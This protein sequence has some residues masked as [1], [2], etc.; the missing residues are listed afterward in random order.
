[1]QTVLQ[2]WLVRAGYAMKLVVA[3][4][5]WFASEAI[6]IVR[7]ESAARINGIVMLD[8]IGYIVLGVF[9]IHATDRRND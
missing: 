9:V 3:S 7:A 5:I 8:K 4:Q 1:M 2:P 6:R